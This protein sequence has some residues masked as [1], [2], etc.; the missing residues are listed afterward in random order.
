MRELEALQQQARD[1]GYAAGLAESRAIARQQ[2]AQRVA[3]L[4]ALF[5]AA[6]RPLQLLDEH[7]AV[8]RLRVGEPGEKAHP[9]V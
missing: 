5:N 1:E 3:D 2:L 6:A 8:V 9:R 4:D 7:A